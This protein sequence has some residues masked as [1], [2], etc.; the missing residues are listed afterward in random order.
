MLTTGLLRRRPMPPQAST[1]SQI[2]SIALIHNGR[3]REANYAREQLSNYQSSARHFA[4]HSRRSIDDFILLHHGA[5][6]KSER[7]DRITQGYDLL[8]VV[9]T[10][11]EHGDTARVQINGARKT[12]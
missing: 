6:R 4:R 3:E 2:R 5:T 1:S 8:E 9:T 11:R 7:D 10:L 12:R